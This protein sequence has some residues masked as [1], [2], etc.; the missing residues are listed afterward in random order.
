MGPYRAAN[1]LLSV[2]SVKPKLYA[3]G[4]AWLH[5][6]HDQNVEI[7]LTGKPNA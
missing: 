1:L 6:S 4:F 7:R 5:F 3:S 2:L